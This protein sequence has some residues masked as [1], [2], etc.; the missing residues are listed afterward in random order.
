MPHIRS[1]AGLGWREAL[2]RDPHL[3]N[4]LQVCAGEIRHPAVAAGMVN[5]G[6]AA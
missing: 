5:L 2:E 1:L 4:G 3:R 6:V